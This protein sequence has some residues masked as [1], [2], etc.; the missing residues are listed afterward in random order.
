MNRERFDL[1]RWKCRCHNL[2]TFASPCK[3]HPNLLITVL[4]QVQDCFAFGLLK[5]CGRVSAGGSST[6]ASSVSAATAAA[7]LSNRDL[8]FSLG[9][10]LI[11]SHPVGHDFIRSCTMEFAVGLL[12]DAV[13]RWCGFD[14]HFATTPLL[15][16]SF[17]TH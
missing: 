13:W 16:I 7:S 14:L 3:F 4:A 15:F 12:F 11:M 1:K 17:C 2:N 5:A 9:F 8:E 10:A 6:S